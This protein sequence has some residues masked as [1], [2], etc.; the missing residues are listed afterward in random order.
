MKDIDIN[1]Y[2]SIDIEDMMNKFYNGEDFDRCNIKGFVQVGR[3][4]GI[5]SIHLYEPSIATPKRI[6]EV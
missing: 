2:N 1:L 3:F 4:P 5:L 6:I